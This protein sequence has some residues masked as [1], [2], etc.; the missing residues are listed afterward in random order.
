MRFSHANHDE[1]QTPAFSDCRKS[2]MT[3][4]GKKVPGRREKPHAVASAWTPFR[5]PVF[6]LLWLATVVANIGGW[7][8][9]AS[10]GWLMT[11]LNADPLM[12]S[13][14]QA[15]SS[16]PLFLLALPAGALADIVDQRRYILMLEILV[17]AASATFAA[18]LSAGFVTAATLL[19]FMFA[20]STLSALEAPA[21]KT[22]FPLD[23][24]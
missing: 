11:S 18:L 17:V 14:V 2:S 13:L 9:N 19:F 22:I 20:I 15:A 7:M 4:S 10:A 23:V 5:N 8:F 24:T 6:R 1:L 12:V 21:W 16:L 3:L